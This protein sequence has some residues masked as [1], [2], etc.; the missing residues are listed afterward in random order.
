M[1]SSLQA[2]SRKVVAP[3]AACNFSPPTAYIVETHDVVDVGLD[4]DYAFFMNWTTSVTLAS[5][6]RPIRGSSRMRR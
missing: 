3:G 6:P 1:K 2:G 5:F 4:E